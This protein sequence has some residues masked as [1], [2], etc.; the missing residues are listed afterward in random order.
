MELFEAYDNKDI[1]KVKQ[2]IINNK[3]NIETKGKWGYTL[4]LNCIM[5]KD[6]DLAKFLIDNNADINN[7]NDYGWTPVLGCMHQNQPEI[8]KLL[9]EK[10]PNVEVKNNDGDT[11]IAI[12]FRYFSTKKCVQYLLEYRYDNDDI[13]I[14]NAIIATINNDKKTLETLLNNGSVTVNS[15]K[16]FDNVTLLHI[17]CFFGHKV[18][19]IIVILLLLLL[20]LL[21]SSS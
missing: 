2:L 13:N 20:L 21:S 4:L 12:G 5:N 1:E 17:S 11:A 14:H 19:V 10:K 9:L 15:K 18:I 7:A 16:D 3:F 6:Y 8:L